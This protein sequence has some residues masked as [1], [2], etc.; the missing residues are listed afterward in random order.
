M[1]ANN[2]YAALFAS[3]D[4][5]DQPLIT[6]IFAKQKKS[7]F[8]SEKRKSSF[9]P[10]IEINSSPI[11]PAINF[12]CTRQLAVDDNV[13]DV[14]TDGAGPPSDDSIQILDDSEATPT[15]FI[16]RSNSLTPTKR[17][18]PKSSSGNS[19]KHRR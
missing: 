7:S 16:T 2:K 3:D 9:S 18:S 8:D 17:S 15:K 6:S 10:A 13:I 12:N 1:A 11:V 4:E 19:S 5:D 14:V